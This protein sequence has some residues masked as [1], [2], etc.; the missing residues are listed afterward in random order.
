MSAF[1]QAFTE[2]VGIEG[3]YSDSE[4]DPGN[5]TGGAVGAGELRGTMYGISA[6]AYPDVDIRSLTLEK[7]KAIYFTDY[8]SRLRCEA[9]PDAVA[10]ALFKQ[11]VNLGVV[12]ATKILQRA[13]RT[14]VD[15]VLGQLTVGLATSQSPMTVLD[16]FLTECAVNYVAMSD[17][18]VEGRGW[19]SRVVRTALEA[20]L[21]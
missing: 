16:E 17:F 9:L 8:W 6:R 7:A 10:V 12:G 20:R 3:R 4:Q 11:A 21:P 5:W 1:D 13:L 18:K 15:G 2:L 14:E 19:L